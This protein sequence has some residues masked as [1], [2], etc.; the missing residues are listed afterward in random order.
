[1]KDLPQLPPDIKPNPNLVYLG[2]GGKNLVF[3]NY[4]K[5]YYIYQ[6]E[7][8]IWESGYVGYFGSHHYAIEFGTT[9]WNRW[10]EKRYNLD[11]IPEG[12]VFVGNNPEE[13][14]IKDFFG[15]HTQMRDGILTWGMTPTIFHKITSNVSQDLHPYYSISK[16]DPQLAK[17][18]EYYC[19][20]PEVAPEI[21]INVADLS[22]YVKY[23]EACKELEEAKSNNSRIQRRGYLTRGISDNAH[24]MKS[25]SVLMVIS[26]SGLNVK[27]S[28]HPHLKLK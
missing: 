19:G 3:H 4:K 26:A 28:N 18:K 24:M 11:P 23:K 22:V 7:L 14:G 1:M 16:T 13:I 27:S 17:V 12:A 9:E 8:G 10:A 2:T 15:R 6:E 21:V 25:T 5:P 20:A